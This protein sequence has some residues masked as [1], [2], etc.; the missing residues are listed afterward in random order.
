M[1]EEVAGSG[2]RKSEVNPNEKINIY[3]GKRLWGEV[4][5]AQKN[6]SHLPG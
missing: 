1:V 3:S 5:S 2:L 4:T 6:C